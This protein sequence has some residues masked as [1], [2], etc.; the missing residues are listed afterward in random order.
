VRALTS[1]AFA[2][3]ATQA[4]HDVRTI[5]PKYTELL[6]EILAARV[7][8]QVMPATQAHP[9]LA[10]D[11]TE[12]VPENFLRD[13]SMTMERLGHLPRYLKAMRLRAERWKQNPTK[14][15]ERAK[16][17]APYLAALSNWPEC[18]GVACDARPDGRASQATPLHNAEAHNAEAHNAGA[19]NAGA[20]NAGAHN[21]G[22]HNAEAQAF[23]WLVEE[24]RVSVFAQELGTSEPVS[25]VKLD[26]VLAAL[27]R[28]A[29]VGGPTAMRATTANAA[30][31][32]KTATT[33]KAATTA[34]MS[35]AA[36]V[37]AATAAAKSAAA[38]PP[39]P[40]RPVAS[41]PLAPQGKKSAPVKSF[42]ALDSLFKRG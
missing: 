17:V 39:P 30:T 19:N 2:A 10:R 15:A 32:T 40:P 37:A 31:T 14:D 29:S 34:A 27:R 9:T 20:N 23:R 4:T 12:L 41:M 13:P 7:A 6:R 38:T 28:G 22:A 3:A 26:K 8:L 1:S 18:R 16:Q 33:T 24:F 11:V 21:A 35:T 25:A 5:I 36:A 42:G